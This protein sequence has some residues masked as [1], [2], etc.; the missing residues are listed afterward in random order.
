[1]AY[2]CNGIVHKK[3]QKEISVILLQAMNP[4]SF[5]LMKE[6]KPKRLLIVCF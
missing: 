1:M 3:E 4:K 2:P 5:L 6:V